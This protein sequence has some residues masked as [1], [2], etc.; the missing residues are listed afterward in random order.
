MKGLLHSSRSESRSIC[1]LFRPCCF[2]DRPWGRETK[3]RPIGTIARQRVTFC[4][5]YFLP[6][7]KIQRHRKTSGGCRVPRLSGYSRYPY[8]D[9]WLAWHKCK[10]CHRACKQVR[11]ASSTP[12]VDTIQSRVDDTTRMYQGSVRTSTL[13]CTR[14]LAKGSDCAF[15]SFPLAGYKHK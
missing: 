10:S 14:V 6:P 8:G 13:G 5:C 3:T 15:P 12:P 9:G 2:V 7:F 1:A 11:P 4:P